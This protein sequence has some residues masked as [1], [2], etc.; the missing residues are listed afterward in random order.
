[1]CSREGVIVPLRF[2]CKDEME[3]GL[4]FLRG[5]HDGEVVWYLLLVAA[6]EKRLKRESL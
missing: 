2:Q 5:R 1:M 3:G 4:C 6:G